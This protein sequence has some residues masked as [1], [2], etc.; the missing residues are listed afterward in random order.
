MIFVLHLGEQKV[1]ERRERNERMDRRHKAAGSSGRDRI[2]QVCR[3]VCLGLCLALGGIWG[4]G[5]CPE[6]AGRTGM[7]QAWASD[8]EP[9]RIQLGK[10][11][12]VW[13]ETKTMGKW[14]SVK[15]AHEYQVKLFESDY[16]ERDEENWQWVDMD[17]EEMIAVATFRTSSTSVDFREYMDDLHTYFFVVRAVPRI[18][19]QGY[20]MTDG[21]V[22]AGAWVGSP[23]MD[24][25]ESPVIGLT[26]G[27][28]RNYLEGSR[29]DDGE[30]NFLP[31][32]WHLIRGDWYLLDE[33][34]YRLSGWQTV[35]G[36]RYYLSEDGRMAT[37]WFVWNGDWY[38]TDPDTGVMQTG[39]LREKPGVYYYLYED[40]RMA[41]DT[42]IDGYRLGSD[43]VRE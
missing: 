9:E 7:M 27:M 22:Q 29:Y 30:G 25:Q 38:Y 23:D 14:S 33:N 42:V 36:Q 21:Y 28:W 17:D 24:F 6:S 5:L 13:W 40:G 10:P 43:G 20:S 34:G 16:V 12:H 35:D 8:K 2:R 41:T 31:G 1:R 11:E 39:W 37:G 19:E 4:A 3:A 15:S 32:G 18:K 26:E